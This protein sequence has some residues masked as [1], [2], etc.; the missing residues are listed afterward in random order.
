[1]SPGVRSDDRSGTTWA[2]RGQT[3]VVRVTGERL[4]PNMISAISPRGN[5][6]FM[7]VR[8]GVGARVFI[9]FLKRL[10]RDR[11]HPVFLTVDERKQWDGLL[12]TLTYRRQSARMASADQPFRE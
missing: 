7:V 12:L 1:M 8:G 10:M 2:P 5:L 9:G 11:R 6:W 4:S 3:P